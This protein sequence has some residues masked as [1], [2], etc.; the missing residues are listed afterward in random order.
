MYNQ[1]SHHSFSS[2]LSNRFVCDESQQIDYRKFKERYF[3]LHKQI[4]SIKGNQEYYQEPCNIGTQ[5]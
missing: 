5:E 1:F 3:A 2:P 4:Q